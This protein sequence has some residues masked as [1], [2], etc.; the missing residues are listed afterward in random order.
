MKNK[1]TITFSLINKEL[2]I[3]ITIFFIAITSFSQSVSINSTGAA[4]NASA[5]LDISFVNYGFLIPRVA[6]SVSTGSAPL[7]AHVAGML[8]YNTA[9]N[10]NITPGLFYND[11][12]KWVSAS[13]QEGVNIGDMQFWNGTAWAII[14]VGSPGQKLQISSTG[15]P[16]WNTGVLSA[17]KTI[18]ASLI[19]STTAQSGGNVTSDG[20]TAVTSRG[21]CWSPIPLP[22][23][24]N[25]KT[26]DGSGSGSFTS[27]LTG[28]NP[29][30][31]YFIRAYAT[32]S[33]GTSYGN[34]VSFTTP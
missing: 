17:I 32:N 25:S 21:V 34:Q 27:N 26:I 4:P 6:L 16:A 12:T 1:F 18:P 29:G 10:E 5:G 31:I 14:P 22:T 13:P 30:T 7:I 3:A 24:A 19:T 23:I 11:G 2:F 9:T 33:A 15:A 20:G 28:L 8:V